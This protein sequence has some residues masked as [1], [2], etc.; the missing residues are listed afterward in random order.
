MNEKYIARKEK[1]LEMHRNNQ[2]RYVLSRRDII[3]NC[4]V[5]KVRQWAPNP[6]NTPYKG[7]LWEWNET[8]SCDV[9]LEN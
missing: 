4:V 5:K 8:F 3:P 9:M 7:H 1:A 2:G 6:A